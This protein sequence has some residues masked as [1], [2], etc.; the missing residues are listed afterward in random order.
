[1][2]GWHDPRSATALEGIP[3]GDIVGTLAGTT[4]ESFEETIGVGA[5]TAV[6]VF[7]V[8]VTAVEVFGVAVTAEE[9]VAWM[10]TVLWSL[11]QLTRFVGCGT[12]PSKHLHE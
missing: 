3:V 2:L 5:A 6:E 7:G 4:V 9:L 1:L 11:T 10:G 12:N 8:A